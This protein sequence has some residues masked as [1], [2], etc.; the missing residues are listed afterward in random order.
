MELQSIMWNNIK[1]YNKALQRRG[2]C[3]SEM[4]AEHRSSNA[5]RSDHRE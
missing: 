4:F 3:V 1:E 2:T 5:A